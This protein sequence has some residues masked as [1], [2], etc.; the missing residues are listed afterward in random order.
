MTKTIEILTV[1]LLREI[2]E[3]EEQG[4]G[5]R[6]VVVQGPMSLVTFERKPHD[7]GELLNAS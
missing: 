2:N 7:L 1:N 6:L 4:W 5:P 3:W